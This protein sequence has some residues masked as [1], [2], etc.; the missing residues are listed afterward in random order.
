[1]PKKKTTLHKLIGLLLN[2]ANTKT[3]GIIPLLTGPFL[4]FK[5]QI[6]DD[7]LIFLLISGISGFIIGY[8]VYLKS[9]N[10]LKKYGINS[11]NNHHLSFNSM[12]FFG[13]LNIFLLFHLNSNFAGVDCDKVPISD[14]YQSE[15]EHPKYF[16]VVKT[17]P[18]HLHIQT[19]KDYWNS[20][21]VQQIIPVCR[22]KG[23]LGF[24]YTS[25]PEA[26]KHWL[27]PH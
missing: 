12:V 15:E 8:Q 22:H 26:P 7:W 25:L 9:K 14:K 21:S 4:Y 13:V 20:V 2:A 19:N 5:I 23:F 27:F 24:G 16:L 17:E 6:L 18:F 10:R 3:F 1:M 11:T